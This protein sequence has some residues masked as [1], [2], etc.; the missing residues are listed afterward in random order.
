MSSFY[1]RLHPGQIIS[2]CSNAFLTSITFFQILESW[3]LHLHL[4]APS[5]YVNDEGIYDA[6]RAISL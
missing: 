6:V 1:S 5:F 3:G 4:L 2:M